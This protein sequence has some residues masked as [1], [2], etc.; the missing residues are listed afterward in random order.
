[1]TPQVRNSK[2]REREREI[3]DSQHLIHAMSSVRVGTEVLFE[4]RRLSEEVVGL[5]DRDDPRREV[6]ARLDD[7]GDQ[8]PIGRSDLDTSRR[9]AR[10]L[11]GLL[12][13]SRESSE[14]AAC[15]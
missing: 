9:R 11:E 14:S 1:M 3:K 10:D 7:Q 15:R 5:L 4:P 6:R 12:I 2:T 8:L 13:W